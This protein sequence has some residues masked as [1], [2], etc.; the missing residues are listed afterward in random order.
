MLFMYF[1]DPTIGCRPN[2]C[3]SSTTNFCEQNC[4]ANA[5][6]TRGYDCNC[7]PL[8][9]KDGDYKCKVKDPKTCMCKKNAYC[10][11]AG[12]CKCIQ[13]FKSASDGLNDDCFADGEIIAGFFKLMK[14]N[15]FKLNHRNTK[16]TSRIMPQ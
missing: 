11:A 9:D 13:G 7:S 6:I 16:R 14:C 10:P 1:I 12:V 4:V 8:Y 2:F 3:Q 15:H 5:N